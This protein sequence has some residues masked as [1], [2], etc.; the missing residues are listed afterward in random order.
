MPDEI[1]IPRVNVPPK[2]GEYKVVQLDIRG[3]PYLRFA[4]EE[5]STHAIILDDL[6]S[7][8]HKECPTIEVDWLTGVGKHHIPAPESD[9]Y[10]VHGMG[11]SK[12]DVERR[13]V[14]L[15]GG[16]MDYGLGISPEHLDSVKPLVP[17]WTFEITTG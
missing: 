15:F 16:S 4:G 1:G 13:K 8:L 14:S 3:Q 11:K 6:A 5:V 7:E 12:V 17:D 9:W 2:S 10:K